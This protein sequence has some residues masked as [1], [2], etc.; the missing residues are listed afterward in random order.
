MIHI[1]VAM[2]R[3]QP[4]STTD[5]RPVQHHWSTV[6][7][8]SKIRCRLRLYTVTYD[9]KITRANV[10]GRCN[11]VVGNG[12]TVHIKRVLANVDSSVSFRATAKRGVYRSSH[13]TL[14]PEQQQQ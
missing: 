13:T 7:E 8:G 2:K 6:L 14:T 1:Y 11:A 5:N 12:L 3:A 10:G 9:G 4:S